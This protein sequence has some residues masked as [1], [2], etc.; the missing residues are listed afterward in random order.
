M[1][2]L[3]W[4]TLLAGEVAEK[5]TG[6]NVGPTQA[7][8]GSCFLQQLDVGS[9]LRMPDSTACWLLKGNHCMFWVP[10]AGTP[11]KECSEMV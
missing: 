2:S 11:L 7:P 9:S 6:F 1:V 3:Q 10:Q 5:L 8:V 4:V